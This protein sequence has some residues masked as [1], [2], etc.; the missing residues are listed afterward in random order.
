METLAAVWGIQ[1][2]PYLY[3]HDVTVITDHSAV[4]AV[5]KAPDPSGWWL[6]VFGSWGWSSENCL[7]TRKGEQRG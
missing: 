7:P 4:G 2:F 1:H 5:L 6:K 3:G